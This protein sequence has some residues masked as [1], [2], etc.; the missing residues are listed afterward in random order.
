MDPTKYVTG[1]PPAAGALKNYTVDELR[2]VATSIGLSID[3]LLEVFDMSIMESGNWIPTFIGTTLP[4]VGTYQTQFGRFVKINRL[5]LANFRIITTAH[6][7]TGQAKFT[8]P[9]KVA[10]DGSGNS[11]GFFSAIIYSGTG[12]NALLSLARPNTSTA[13]LLN[14]VPIAAFNIV[15]AMDIVGSFSY[16][17]D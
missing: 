7:G 6:T 15:N 10:D 16:Y 11:S 3:F 5:V 14:T 12:G 8:L 13:D 2:K 17:T 4:G 9:F 1:H